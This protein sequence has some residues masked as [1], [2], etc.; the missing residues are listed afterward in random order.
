[1]VLRLNIKKKSWCKKRKDLAYID[2]KAT[3]SMFLN[4]ELVVKTYFLADVNTYKHFSCQQF[5]PVNLHKQLSP[6]FQRIIWAYMYFQ[7]SYLTNALLGMDNSN[8]PV[9]SILA[10]IA[11][12]KN[13]Q[14][15]TSWNS[16]NIFSIVPL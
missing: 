5:M 6:I 13:H 16:Y 9:H 2:L 11:K 8:K 15:H 7:I 10:C 14:L 1:M 4:V 3:G 12:F